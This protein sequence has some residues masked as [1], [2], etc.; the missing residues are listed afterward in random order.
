M[1]SILIRCPIHA[2]LCYIEAK[3]LVNYHSIKTHKN[4]GSNSLSPSAAFKPYTTLADLNTVLWMVST[5]PLISKSSSHFTKYLGIVPSIPTIG[6]TVTFMFHSCF[7]LVTWQG[8]G[9]YLSF[10]F[11]LFLFCGR[12]VRQ[13][14]LFGNR[15]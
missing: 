6:I 12:P 3:S 9:R 8:Q 14:L 11:L 5:C 4:K 15:Q 7:F 10:R 1:S 2:A 13:S